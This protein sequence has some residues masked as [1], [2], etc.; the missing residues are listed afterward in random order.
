MRSAGSGGAPPTPRTAAHLR[1]FRAGWL[2]HVATR[3]CQS[4]WK[5]GLRIMPFRLGAMAA[6][7]GPAGAGSE[8]GSGLRPARSPP[9]PGPRP[10]PVGSAGPKPLCGRAWSSPTPMAADGSGGRGIAHSPPP[11]ETG[12]RKRTG[13]A[14]HAGMVLGPANH[15]SANRSGQSESG[16]AEVTR[17]PSQPPPRP[18]ANMAFYGSR[19]LV[20]GP[21]WRTAGCCRTQW[22]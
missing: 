10:S 7:Y 3:R 5:W 13:G 6:T 16:I 14:K 17:T 8:S 9:E 15:K 22:P 11:R 1:I 20:A 12:Q 18:R 4:L 21:C 19:A 2:N